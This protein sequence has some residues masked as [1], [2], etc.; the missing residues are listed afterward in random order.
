MTESIER[1]Q[2]RR[3][4]LQQAAKR[5]RLVLLPPLEILPSLQLTQA[6]LDYVNAPRVAERFDTASSEAAA[7]VTAQT[8]A[9]LAELEVNYDAK[10][11]DT[12]TTE[13]RGAVLHTVAGAFGVGKLT[14][15]IRK[16]RRRCNHQAYGGQ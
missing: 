1:F 4:A 11:F 8:H 2:R 16:G 15:R 7:D 5:P 9:L 10:R 3:Q 14:R 12:M 13:M 6:D